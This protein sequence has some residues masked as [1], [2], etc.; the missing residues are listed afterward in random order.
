MHAG[1]ASS[2]SLLGTESSTLWHVAAQSL[3]PLSASGAP[4]ADDDLIE[5]KTKV[6]ER[7]L[8]AEAAAF[9]KQ[10]AKSN[11]ADAQWLQTVR[12]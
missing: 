4:A 2:K 7:L 5:T 9:Q 12:R 11:P 10:M 6:A 8:E 3:P 1:G